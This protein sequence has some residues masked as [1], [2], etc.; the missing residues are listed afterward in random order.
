MKN[1][2]VAKEDL[3]IDYNEKEGRDLPGSYEFSGKKH[4]V[5]CACNDNWSRENRKKKTRPLLLIDIDKAAFKNTFCNI[6]K[7]SPHIVVN[8]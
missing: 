5:M 1:E 8:K 7:M 4:Q 6:C 2:I 3:V